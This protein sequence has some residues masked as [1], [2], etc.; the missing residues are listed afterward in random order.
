[1][2]LSS[3]GWSCRWP[4]TPSSQVR[5]PSPSTEPSTDPYNLVTLV[6]VLWS[7]KTNFRATDTVINRLI[8]G[9]IQTGLFASI[10]S[11]GDMLAF[12][13]APETN[14]YGM[15]AIPL[16]RIYTNVSVCFRVGL[17]QWIDGGQQTLMDTL[18]MR[19]GLRGILSKSADGSLVRLLFSSLFLFHLRANSRSPLPI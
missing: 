12:S 9:A 14:F 3:P 10:F 4:S 13:L 5:F 15:F 16:G 19:E 7:A 6:F 8:R 2:V 18:L 11:L 17:E 1:M